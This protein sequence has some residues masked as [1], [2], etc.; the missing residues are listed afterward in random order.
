MDEVPSD[1]TFHYVCQ[2]KGMCVWSVDI[3]GREAHA[4][5]LHAF[6]RSAIHAAADLIHAAHALTDYDQVHGCMSGAS[7]GGGTGGTNTHT[8]DTVLQSCTFNV[9]TIAGGTATNTVAGHTT[10]TIEMRAPTTDVFNAAAAKFEDFCANYRHPG[11]E[12]LPSPITA[13]TV[14]CVRGVGLLQA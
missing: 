3:A 2:R 6:G 13:S 5:N 4:G 1:K 12:D 11:M 14:C 7:G 10:M 8:A 9:G